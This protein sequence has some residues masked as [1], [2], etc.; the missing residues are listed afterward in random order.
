MFRWQSLWFERNLAIQ[1]CLPRASVLD[2][3]P[4]FVLGLWRSGT[5]YL[6]ELLSAC[7]GLH[8]PSTA[9]CMNPASF[10]LRAPPGGEKSAGRPMDGLTIDTYSP[11]EDEFALLALGV[12][13]AYRGFFDPRRLPE[14][15]HW[16]DPD[17]WAA[18]LP[19]GWAAKW[20][21]FLLGVQ[22]GATGRL[23][24]K[25]PGHSFRINALPELFP[26]AAFIWLVRDP[27][28]TFFSNRKMWGAMLERYALWDWDTEMIDGFLGRA[29]ECAAESL[30]RA[31]ILLPK[32][33]LVV[34]RFSE[35]TGAT[36]STMQRANQRLTLGS[37]GGMEPPLT[38][39]A[40]ERAAYRPEAYEG[41]AAPDFVARA[42]G[43]LGSAQEAALSSHGL[44]AK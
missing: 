23:V 34:M 36:V 10:R 26:R 20:I 21:E 3:D 18:G 35:L 24:I 12:P 28:E 19:K 44:D 2:Q 30:R 22:A 38:R 9:Q 39:I 11:Q 6:H 27:L 4:L 32:E 14:L 16:L 33:R 25:S 15:T 17:N 40:G 41:R 5:T 1:A 8:S 29:F 7:P 13:S 42:A 37:W 31:T 43:R